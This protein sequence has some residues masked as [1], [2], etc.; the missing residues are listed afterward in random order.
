MTGLN[1]LFLPPFSIVARFFLTSVFLGLLG[2]LVAL[3]MAISGNFNLPALVHTYTLG[4][5]TMTMLGAL[6]Q[7]LPVVAGAVIENPLS[8][9][10]FTHTTFLAGILLFIPGLLLSKDS[11]LYIGLI[12]IS[13]S[14]L[15]TVSL[16]LSKLLRL[17]SYT[18]TSLGMKVALALFLLAFF[19][20]VLL[21]FASRGLLSFDYTYLLELHLGIMLWGWVALLIASV[22]FRVIEMFFVTPPYPEGFARRFP[23]AVAG[24]IALSALSGFHPATKA[25]I[26][27]LFIYFA[28][29]TIIRLVKRR[30]KIPDPLISFWYLGMAFLIGSSVL[31]PFTLLSFDLFLIYLYL[32]G[33][34]AQS[35]ILA[36]MYRII[37]FLIW[38]HLSNKGVKDAPTM[39]EVIKPRRIWLNFYLHL[40]CIFAFLLAFAVKHNGFWIIASSFY[41]L[42]FALLLFNLSSGVLTYLRKAGWED[43][44]PQRL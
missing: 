37:P 18:P 32:F 39:H 29:L 19:A 42:S 28:I 2:A 3:Y 17:K 20:G 7:M 13:V 34:F 6:F 26:Y 33:T 25:L 41:A 43:A 12:T 36:M 4:F 31:Y 8:K 35:V 1:L 22:A 21:L 15:F 40:A 24:S 14:L 30:R 38:I 10:T 16:M 44:S 23:F 9:A 11:L 5:M 27:L